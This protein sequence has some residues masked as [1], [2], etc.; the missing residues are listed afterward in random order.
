M[1]HREEFASLLLSDQTDLIK[2]LSLVVKPLIIKNYSIN[3][4]Y[5]AC[6][7][8]AAPLFIFEHFTSHIQLRSALITCDNISTSL[9]THSDT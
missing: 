4:S 5:L 7:T 3:I 2:L 8:V 6:E 1:K 9:E